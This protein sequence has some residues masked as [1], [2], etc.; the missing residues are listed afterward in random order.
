MP[1]GVFAMSTGVRR[2]FKGTGDNRVQEGG[3]ACLVLSVLPACSHTK[4]LWHLPAFPPA[5]PCGARTAVLSG[6]TLGRKEMSLESMRVAHEVMPP[7]CHQC[8][9]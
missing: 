4:A 8:C 9:S 5:W 2:C 3:H 6:E 7:P 1:G